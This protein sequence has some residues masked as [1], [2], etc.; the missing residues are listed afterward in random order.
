MGYL[1]DRLAVVL[2]VARVLL[3]DDHAALAVYGVLLQQHAVRIVAQ[4]HE[5]VADELGRGFGHVE[6]VDRLYKAG[7]RV[8]VGA[9]RHA[10][11]LEVFDHLARREMLRAV[12][13]H[14]L[15]EVGKASLVFELVRRAA[16]YEQAHRH[17]VGRLRVFIDRD[18]HPVGQDLRFQVF[19]GLEF[20]RG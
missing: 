7:V 4:K 2:R 16:L 17:P 19:V 3:G 15:E 14:V 9:E 10:E 1:L 20:G 11:A 18:G 8:G 6:L 5:A 12:E 13:G